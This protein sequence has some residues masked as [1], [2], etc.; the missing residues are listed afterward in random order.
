MSGIVGG[1]GTRSGVIGTMSAGTITSEVVR[2]PDSMF[3]IPMQ[4]LNA[5]GSKFTDTEVKLNSTSYS[6]LRSHLKYRYFTVEFDIKGESSTNHQGFM[7]GNTSTTTVQAGNSTGWRTTWQQA[8]MHW[9]RECNANSG[10]GSSWNDG[11]PSDNAWHHHRIQ[12]NVN[13]TTYV[14]TDGTLRWQGAYQQEGYVGLVCYT[15][16]VWF[17]NIQLRGWVIDV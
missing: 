13:G 5:S 4:N 3:Y 11:N 10:V 8:G 14:F 1:V 9:V 15:G 7:W 12:A 16:N 6:G 17:K 2:S